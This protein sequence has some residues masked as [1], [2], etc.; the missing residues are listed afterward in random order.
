MIYVKYKVVSMSQLDLSTFPL[1]V[2]QP[3]LVSGS[4]LG[5]EDVVVSN[6]E[7]PPHIRAHRSDP[8]KFADTVQSYYQ[9]NT[10]FFCID[11]IMK[12]GHET[13]SNLDS[14]SANRS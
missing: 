13:R 5:D 12:A 1:E 3:S 6:S 11:G 8:A 4:I 9:S 10:F 14:K 2:R 7:I